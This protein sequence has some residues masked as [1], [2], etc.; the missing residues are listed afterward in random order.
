V[1]TAH[2]L[3]PL[4]GLTSL[5][6][7]NLLNCDQ[8]SDFS[9]LAELTSL[10]TFHFLSGCG[11]LSDL[12][13]LAEMTS[14]QTLKLRG[15]DQLSD[16]IPLAGLTSLQTLDLSERQE[17]GEDSKLTLIGCGQLTDLSPLARLKSLRN[18]DLSE[19]G[20]L[21]DL[22]PVAGLT[23]LNLSGCGQ[24]IDINP[25]ARLISLRELNLS[26][27]RKLADINP[28]AG[29]TSLQAL[30]L[31]GCG[32]LS[33]LSPLSEL[34]SLQTL[35][36]YE[37]LGIRRF[38][39]L[40]S[41]LLT[42]G[43]LVLFGCNFDDLPSEVCGES[44]DENVL[45]KVRAHYEDLKSGP[46][47]DAEVK[48]LFLG[49]GGAGKTQ[50]CRR[51]RD[52][53]FD[54]N[55]PTTHGIQLGQ[56]T[57]ELVEFPEPVNLN[58]WDFGGQD[59]YHSAHSLFLHGQAIFLLLWTP[60]L[61][62][63][64]IYQEGE[65]FF[66]HRPLSYWA[67]YLRAFAGTD[68]SVL[69]VQSQCDTRDQRKLHPPAPVDDLPF[70]RYTEVSARTGLN[71]GI[72]KE[73]IKEAVRDRLERRPPPPIGLG[74]AAVRDRLRQMLEEDQKRKPDKRQNRLL[75]RAEFDHLC[76]EVGGITDK[77]ALLDFLHHNG[78][79]F[80]RP[81]LFGNRIVLDQNW[82]LEAIYSIF[83]REKI[84]PLLRGYGR[85]S[86][87][88]LERLI[89]SDFRLEEQK[90]FLGMMESCGICFKVRELPND[91][92]E[93]L[94]PE[95]LP[96]WSDAQKSLLTGRIPKDQPIAQAEARYAFLHDGVLRGYLSKI[97]QQAGD[98]ALYWKY[99][100]WSYEET[101]DSRVLIESQWDAAERE[102]G[103]GSIR[104]RAWGKNAET[105]LNPLLEGLQKLPIGQPPEIKRTKAVSAKAIIRSSASVS[106][107]LIPTSPVAR[108]PDT[109]ED[110]SLKQVDRPTQ[111]RLQDL[112]FA[113]DPIMKDFFI[114][115]TKADQ[116]WA[117]WIAWTLEAA[118]YSTVIQA[119]DFG[120]G[121]N[122]VLEMQRAAIEANR[123]IAVLSQKYLE[124]TFTQPEWAAAF[125]QDP[126]GKNLFRYESLLAS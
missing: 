73:S 33:D 122:F 10:H 56:M 6:T 15:C 25:L 51:L 117:E 70:H 126:Q 61:E 102:A 125:A 116:A 14:L 44:Y 32:Q 114:S 72:L 89:W 120:P 35:A 39:S 123:T 53:P 97:G 48:V 11:R 3:S 86:R 124:S 74:R 21:S 85:F 78:V 82:A 77:E 45:D 71:L 91:E 49:N 112:I 94:A 37:C 121:S 27:C 30:N 19:C 62:Y 104:L 38:A 9:P 47:Q 31:S 58:L 43:E 1:R 17:C 75:E 81:G 50:L 7:L 67:D 18:L 103:A 41:V 57:V 118:G 100:C 105:L 55:I 65:L 12:S 83:N 101:T 95:L 20:Q 16:L 119:W 26:R 23:S 98:A 28:L 93:Y 63:Q 109:N 115:Y 42:L 52:L 96:E 68:A 13:P 22:K 29:L 84:L 99:G 106:V 2:R 66:R 79:V 46:R 36:L 34:T 64:T 108:P 111:I 60:E 24:L 8:L 87:K 107:R 59:I 113:R 40:E 80:Y 88:D 69:I 54:P 5:Q 110:V 92:W 76:D 90:V 4:T